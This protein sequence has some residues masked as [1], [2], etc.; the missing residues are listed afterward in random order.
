MDITA[1]HCIHPFHEQ[2]SNF[3]P[4]MPWPHSTAILSCIIIILWHVYFCY[5][6]WSHTEVREGPQRPANR[7]V[8]EYP[9]ILPTGGFLHTQGQRCGWVRETGNF[10]CTMALTSVYSMQ[11]LHT[12][13]CLDVASEAFFKIDSWE[14]SRES[15]I[16]GQNLCRWSVGSVLPGFSQK[17][18][19]YCPLNCFMLAK[20]ER[21]GKSAET[22]RMIARH[23]FFPCGELTII[24][25][26][27]RE[28]KI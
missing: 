18:H 11:I 21:A 7:S 20:R 9:Y 16:S 4:H 19:P 14:R 10:V 5:Y 13:S 6:S 17:R 23:T 27:N 24:P 3:E 8:Y 28:I 1:W 26:E 2:G 12:A 15:G 22:C 25:I